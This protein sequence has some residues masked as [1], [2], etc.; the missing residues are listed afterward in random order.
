MNDPVEHSDSCSQLNCS[1]DHSHDGESLPSAAV[2]AVR[3]APEEPFSRVVGLMDIA[4]VFASTICTVHCLLMPFVLLVLPVLAGHLLHHDYVHVGLAGFVLTFCLMAYIPG[5]LKH[6]DR[7]LVIAGVVGMTLV[8][9]ATFV[10]RA[11]GEV[12]EAVIITAGNTVI[13]FGH[14]LN[15]R[16]L[17]HLKCKHR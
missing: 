13:I 14:L 4:G 10:A 9:F 12:T 17:A 15:R 3:H 16:L 8:F 5:Y 11:W 6:H 1:H 2:A 7:R